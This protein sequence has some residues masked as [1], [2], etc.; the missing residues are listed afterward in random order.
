[1][2]TMFLLFP[3]LFSDLN[4]G[5]F[6]YFRRDDR[7]WKD[8]GGTWNISWLKNFEKIT[9][10]KTNLMISSSKQ[11]FEE[12]SLLSIIWWWNL[13]M[14]TDLEPLMQTKSTKP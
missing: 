14:E 5:S 3:P 13:V 12:E 4:D 2:Q 9:Y 1:M 10:L 11:S 6:G 8:Q 7:C